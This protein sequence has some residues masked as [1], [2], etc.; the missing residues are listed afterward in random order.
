MGLLF[1]DRC[2][3]VV[4]GQ[5]RG[6]ADCLFGLASA[7]AGRLFLDFGNRLDFFCFVGRGF[8]NRFTVG[9]LTLDGS[10]FGGLLGCRGTATFALGGSRL[11][12]YGNGSFLLGGFGLRFFFCLI[13]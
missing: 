1:F 10:L 12:F 7:T 5:N 2:I 8:L 13:A 9:W 3:D 4:K 6:L 11:L